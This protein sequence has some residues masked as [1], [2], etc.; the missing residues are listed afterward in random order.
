VLLCQGYRTP[1]EAVVVEFGAVV[2]CSLEGKP[3]Y[4]EKNLLKCHLI[5]H[6]YHLEHTGLN[7]ALGGE[8][9]CLAP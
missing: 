4:S 1:R 2:E 7:P 6:K 8:K 5:H 3:K 9:P